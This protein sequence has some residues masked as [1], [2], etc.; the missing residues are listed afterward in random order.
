MAVTQY[1]GARYVPLFYENPNGTN[2]WLAG[3]AYDPLTI[4]TYLTQSFTSKKPVPAGIGNPVENPEYWAQT[5]AYNAQVEQYRQEVEA[6]AEEV[7][8]LSGNKNQLKNRKI[9]F[10]G[11]SYAQPVTEDHGTYNSY[12]DIL[13][14]KSY[15]NGTK[16][17][18]G[19]AGFVGFGGYSFIDGLRNANIADKDTYTD[20][21]VQG[22]VNDC[23]ADISLN[24]IQ[25]AI[26]DFCEYCEDNFVNA[27]IHIAFIAAITP[28]ANLTERARRMND[29]F[30]AYATA[31]ADYTFCTFSESVLFDRSLV[32]NV[33][34][35]EAGQKAIADYFIHYLNGS[36][37]FKKQW[38][39]RM[40]IGAASQV[41]LHGDINNGTVNICG[42]DSTQLTLGEFS[43]TSGYNLSTGVEVGNIPNNSPLS[44]IASAAGRLLWSIP[45]MVLLVP[46]SNTVPTTGDRGCFMGILYPNDTGTKLKLQV[47]MPG[48]ISTF[49]ASVF[50]YMLPSVIHQFNN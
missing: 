29:V 6:L 25:S 41:L 24:A 11:D 12:V 1:I 4:V 48:S 35:T 49:T 42:L 10:I 30:T 26:K 15:I 5:G 38:N 43:F 18:L 47:D 2:E 44:T 19:G 31:D 14:S 3:I 21:C 45:C 20:I 33:H 13:L 17:A 8:E 7:E 37:S 16:L 23:S 39:T 32:Y 40:N 27:R 22:G 28:A 50:I 34:P 9:L 46:I 36:P